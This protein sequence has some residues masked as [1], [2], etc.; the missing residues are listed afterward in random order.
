MDGAGETTRR[1]HVSLAPG[2]QKWSPVGGWI[3]VRFLEAEQIRRLSDEKEGEMW[4]TTQVRWVNGGKPNEIAR[5]TMQ[6]NGT[7]L[8]QYCSY[9]IRGSLVFFFLTFF[10][11]VL[12]RCYCAWALGSRAQ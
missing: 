7:L 11:A 9:Y 4:L 5:L 6:P 2:Q 10:W 12:G 3:C 1:H 8:Q